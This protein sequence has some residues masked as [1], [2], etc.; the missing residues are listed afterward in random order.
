MIA[1][2]RKSLTT[3]YN[4]RV[5][6]KKKILKIYYKNSLNFAQIP[7]QD[8][9]SPVQ[10]FIYFKYFKNVEEPCITFS[11]LKPRKYCIIIRR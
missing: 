11:D 10:C 2:S 5:T 8:V 3:Y 1:E 6:K 9:V 7:Y 4:V